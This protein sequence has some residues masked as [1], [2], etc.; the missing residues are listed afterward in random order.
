MKRIGSILKYLEFIA[1]RVVVIVTCVLFILRNEISYEETT[2][3]DITAK[4]SLTTVLEHNQIFMWV[5]G[6]CL[7]VFV[8][9]TFYYCFKGLFDKID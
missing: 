9:N 1:C 6:V 2:V 8:L 3:Q 5:Y 4:S 7:L